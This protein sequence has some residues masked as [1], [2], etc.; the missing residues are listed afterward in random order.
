MV[1][2]RFLVQTEHANVGVGS[3]VVIDSAVA[4]VD[5]AV[6]VVDAAVAGFTCQA[7]Q[8]WRLRL[9]FFFRKN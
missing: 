3:F 5:A 4:V 9:M 2:H 1:S 6:A 8:W 7:R